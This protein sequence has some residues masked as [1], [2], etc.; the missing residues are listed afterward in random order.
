MVWQLQTAKQKFS[1][2][3]ERALSEGPQIV[4]R[5]GQEVV[6]V[7]DIEEYRRLR[8]SKRESALD[9]PPYSDEFAAILEE[10][11]RDRAAQPHRE[12]EL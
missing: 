10:I 5:H 4:T 6:A 12:I 11:V 8:G 1:E 9:G 2:L 7:I 3:V